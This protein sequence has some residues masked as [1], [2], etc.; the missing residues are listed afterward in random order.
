MYVT[1]C[2]PIWFVRAFH[3]LSMKKRHNAFL[4]LTTT[5]LRVYHNP[6]T[7]LT[8][9]ALLPFFN[10]HILCSF[11]RKGSNVP[12]FYNAWIKVAMISPRLTSLINISLL[13]ILAIVATVGIP[14]TTTS[15]YLSYQVSCQELQELPLLLVLWGHLNLYLHFQVWKH[16]ILIEIRLRLGEYSTFWLLF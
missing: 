5:R 14:V 15:A 7:R 13:T 16:P 10:H 2:V 1:I 8:P 4:C 6:A 3:H 9:R 12:F 11:Q